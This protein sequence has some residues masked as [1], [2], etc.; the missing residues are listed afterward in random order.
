M[1]TLRSLLIRAFLYY[2]GETLREKHDMKIL[3][4]ILIFLSFNLNA[5]VK[6]IKD[7]DGLWIW[8]WQKGQ[9]AFELRNGKIKGVSWKFVLKKEHLL[10]NTQGGASVNLV[11]Q[12]NGQ[13]TGIEQPTGLKI[14]MSRPEVIKGLFPKSLKELNGKWTWQWPKGK[15]AFD[16]KRGKRVDDKKWKFRLMKNHLLIKLAKHKFVN[17]VLVKENEWIGLEVPTSYPIIFKKAE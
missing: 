13:W 11:Q 10:V 7:L 1:I 17:M 5:G 4:L 15:V 12:E 16:L 6:R 3:L 14:I 2:N 9:T 8:N